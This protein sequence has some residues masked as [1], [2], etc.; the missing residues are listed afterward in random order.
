MVS[1]L[2]KAMRLGSST[3]MQLF[4]RLLQLVEKHSETRKLFQVKVTSRV[5]SLPAALD[6]PQ[7][8]EVPCWM[9]IGWINQMVA[10]LDKPEGMAVH[11]ILTSIATE[12]PQVGV[13][14]L[15]SASFKALP[16]FAGP[17]LPIQD[18]H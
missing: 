12:Y 16:F 1:H 14:V 11:D 5:T 8:K 18:Q 15:H 17:M 3:A 10:L 2:L 6:I 7:A 9:F 4:P 13:T